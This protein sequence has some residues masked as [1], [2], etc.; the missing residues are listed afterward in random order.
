MEKQRKWRRRLTDAEWDLSAKLLE[1]LEPAY[2][3]ME[4]LQANR[5]P[6]ISRVLPAVIILRKHFLSFGTTKPPLIREVVR[7]ID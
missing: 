4:E 3:I 7:M 1:L 5:K 2:R 6:T